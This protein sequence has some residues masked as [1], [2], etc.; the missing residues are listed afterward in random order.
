MGEAQLDLLDSHHARV[1]LQ[2]GRYHQ[3]KRMFAACSN[4]V[5]TL[6]RE[7]I[8]NIVLDAGLA[9]GQWR[10]LT[11]AEVDGISAGRVSHE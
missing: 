2:E 3:V 5:E 4:R 6:H 1:T 8:G 7:R 9:P 11:Q 10:E